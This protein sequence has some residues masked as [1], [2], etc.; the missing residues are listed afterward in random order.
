MTPELA[1]VVRAAR[2]L[3]SMMQVSPR[4]EVCHFQVERQ[5]LRDALA[6][7]DETT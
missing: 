4:T 7:L 5:D 6:K 1:A 2:A 3:E